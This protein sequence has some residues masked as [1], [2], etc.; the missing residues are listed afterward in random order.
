VPGGVSSD[1]PPEHTRFSIKEKLAAEAAAAAASGRS[2][3]SSASGR[4]TRAEVDDEW[5]PEGLKERNI[6]KGKKGRK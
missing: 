2:S 3:P 4:K 1:A 5:L 6:G